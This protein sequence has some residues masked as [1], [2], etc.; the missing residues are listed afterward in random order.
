MN[1]NHLIRFS[2]VFIKK[3]VF[4]RSYDTKIGFPKSVSKSHF[5]GHP[6]KVNNP[7]VGKPINIVI[8][9]AH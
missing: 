7:L 4:H 3:N 2:I 9:A 1:E 6:I 8:I 5:I